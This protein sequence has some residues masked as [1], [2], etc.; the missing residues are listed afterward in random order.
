M[1]INEVIFKVDPNLIQV[2]AKGDLPLYKAHGFEEAVKKWFLSELSKR[3]KDFKDL[4]QEM[5][6]NV[7][8]AIPFSFKFYEG[9]SLNASLSEPMLLKGDYM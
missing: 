5:E 4:L 1:T 3:E 7:F 9:I 6:N 2:N 8:N